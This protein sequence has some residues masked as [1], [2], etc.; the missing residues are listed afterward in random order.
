MSS[1]PGYKAL[2]PGCPITEPL[3][4]VRNH[5]GSW[6]SERPLWNHDLCVK[7]GVCDLFC[8]EACISANAAGFF[9]ANLDYCKGCGICMQECPTRCISMKQEEE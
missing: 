6:R 8:P 7:C 3:S 9:E 1:L 4:A 2:L 5:T